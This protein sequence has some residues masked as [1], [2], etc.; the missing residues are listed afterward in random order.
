MFD[1]TKR[2]NPHYVP[3]ATAPDEFQ[4]QRETVSAPTE[5]NWADPFRPENRIPRHIQEAVVKSLETDASHY[6]FPLGSQELRVEIAK[7][8]NARYGLQLDATKNITVSGGSDNLFAF[9]LLPFLTAGED[10]E[11]MTL[12]PSYSHNQ[13][14]PNLIG[15]RTVLV[16][17]YPEDNYEIHIEE[18]EKRVTE[19]T[20]A[21]ILVNP[22]NPTGTVYSRESL[23]A[24]ADFV[25]RH[26]LILI[27]DQAFEDTVYDGFTLTCPAAL[28]G[29]AERTVV[30]GSISK[31][32][33]LCGFRVAY[34]AAPDTISRVY[35][36]IAVLI[37]GAPNTMA[38]AGAVAAYRD[39][40]FVEDYR[41]EFMERARVLSQ[42]LREIPHIS[43]EMPQSGFFFWIDISHYGT[44]AE[45]VAYLLKEANVL[46]S[47][48]SM[49]GSQNHI[50]IIF[51]TLGNM[52]SCVETFRRIRDAMLRHPLA[53][54]DE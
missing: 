24:L 3:F 23:E 12:T 53:N 10:N 48:G 50:R 16:P 2:M 9:S 42:V 20:K 14:V 39:C 4:T 40:G 38:Q 45:I 27:V 15:G 30:F 34:I 7:R 33:G 6:T 28:E 13:N 18:F 32:M 19:K 36:S 17:T 31:G 43:F 51:G 44:D 37:L 41:K 46:V 26:D 52:D 21:V 8:L 47:G 49:C 25:K 22:N 5:M 29:M 1:A 35:Q 54:K 11:V